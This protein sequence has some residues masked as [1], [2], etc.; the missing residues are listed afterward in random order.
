MDR[1]P[2]RHHVARHHAVF[3]EGRRGDG[4]CVRCL[5][6]LRAAWSSRFAPEKTH[7]IKSRQSSTP[8][9]LLCFPVRAAAPAARTPQAQ[10]AR[11]GATSG[12]SRLRKTP[13]PATFI[14]RSSYITRSSR[15]HAAPWLIAPGHWPRR[16]GG[17][18][19]PAHKGPGSRLAE[20]PRWHAR[21]A[22]GSR[23][24]ATDRAK[25]RTPPDP[26]P[27]P[28]RPARRTPWSPRKAVQQNLNSRSAPA[29]TS[30][31]GLSP[32]QRKARHA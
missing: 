3:V 16:P 28:S 13:R 24:D 21:L 14:K 1:S 2:D 7:Y 12:S 23:R 18:R 8:L 22:P 9:A 29:E 19:P 11:R 27:P 31:A 15:L 26:G 20:L 5:W 25:E 30:L 4:P 10:A 17:A 32:D 6:W